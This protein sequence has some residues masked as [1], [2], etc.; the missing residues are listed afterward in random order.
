MEWADLLQRS[1]T[2]T[3][4][5]VVGGARGA[6]GVVRDL[7]SEGVPVVAMNHEREAPALDSRYCAPAI[8]PDPG[9]SEE[10]FIR[11]LE[12]VGEAL[13]RRAVLLPTY[14]GLVDAVS[15]HKER[16]ERVYHVPVMPWDRMSRLADKEQQ[17]VVA[18]EAGVDVPR[19]A[20]VTDL[21]D[22]REAAEEVPFPAVLK[23]CTPHA[24]LDQTGLKAAG[25]DTREDLEA[26]YARF[27][28]VGTMLLQEVIPARND[29]IAIAAGYWDAQSRPVATFTGR[30]LRQ[31]PRQFGVTRL[32]ESR[33]LDEVADLAL[34]FL[35]EIS[36]HGL[37]DLEFMLD[38]RDGRYKFIEIN[39]RQPLWVPLATAAG[40]N[41][42]LIAYKDLTGRPITALPQ[43]D[44]VGWM[45]LWQDG[46]DSLAEWRRGELSLREWVRPL[47]RVRADAGLSIR[48]P[49][50]VLTELGRRAATRAGRAARPGSDATDEGVNTTATHSGTRT[51]RRASPA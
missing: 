8:Y 47:A 16:L 32:A 49:P 37:Y 44:G 46:P 42:S 5:V 38:P 15:R 22:L 27:P 33:W 7:G 39:A 12:A 45:N 25:V 10:D 28:E 20:L 24:M 14:E 17:L 50:P 34:R 51:P 18:R 29:A 13:P 6:L 19:S 1:T 21:D 30:K 43:R 40:V 4:A 11:A 26:T 3:P 31:H 36:Y 48:D 41:L 23:P 9:E 2:T 35:D